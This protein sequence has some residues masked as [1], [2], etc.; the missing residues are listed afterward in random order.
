[1][2]LI[3]YYS[4]EA[5]SFNDTKLIDLVQNAIRKNK[6]EGLSGILL[7]AGG[8]FFQIIEGPDNAIDALYEKIEIDRRHTAVSKVLDEPISHRRFSEWSMGGIA[9]DPEISE[10][11]PVFEL[12]IQALNKKV[13]VSNFDILNILIN[14]FMKSSSQAIT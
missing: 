1:M 7:Y 3:A 13:T 10:H 9:L 8:C 6:A 11:K 2:K 14:A 4:S 12:S 5:R